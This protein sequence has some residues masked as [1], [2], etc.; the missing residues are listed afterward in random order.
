MRNTIKTSG[1][2]I[3]L[4]KAFARRREQ[5]LCLYPKRVILTQETRV[6]NGNLPVTTS[7]AD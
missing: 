5:R 4:L 3:E 6:L 1:A 2:R 7:T